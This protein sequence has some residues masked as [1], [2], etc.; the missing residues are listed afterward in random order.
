METPYG[1]PRASRGSSQLRIQGATDSPSLKG[2]LSD[3]DVETIF[4]NSASFQQK[5]KKRSWNACAFKTWVFIAFVIAILLPS[6]TYALDAIEYTV[7]VTATTTV[8]P[9]QIILNWTTDEYARSFTIRRKLK[10]DAVWSSPLAVLAGSAITFTDL[11]V[12]IGSAYEYEIQEETTIYPYPA[13]NPSDWVTAYGYIYAGIATPIND[14]P[15][16]VLLLVDSTYASDLNTELQQ[17]SN[18]LIGDG[19]VVARRDISRSSRPSEVKSAVLNEYNADPANLKALFLIGH[20]PVPYS[21]V[22][23]PDM[24][25]GHIGAW[26][27]DLYYGD[28]HGTWTDN[29]ANKTDSEDPRNDNVP[30]DGKFDQ[31]NI[32]SQVELQVGRVDMFDL[33]AFSPRTERDLLRQYLIKDH[34]FRQKLVTTERRGLVRD[35]FGDLAGDAP[36]VDAWRHFIPFFGFDNIRVAN[37]GE[38]FPILSDDSYLWSYGCGGGSTDKADGVGSTADFAATDVKSV[39]LMLHGS[40]FG[41]WDVTDNFL[42]AAIATPTYSLAAIWTGLPHWFMHHMG[43]GET[44]GYSTL[45]S[46]NNNNQLYKNRYNF[47]AGQVHVALLGDP[48]LRMDVV[49]PPGN[50]TARVSASL[51]LNWDSPPDS[52]YG[53]NVYHATSP[54]G[55][56]SKL[57]SGYV[58]GNSFTQRSIS[59]GQH[60]FMIR[61]V[62]LQTSPSGSY[63][64]LSQG[65]FLTIN[66]GDPNLPSVS[67][68]ASD[69]EASETGDTGQFTLSR[70]GDLSS[71]L[72]I[73]FSTGG[74]AQNGR[75]YEDLGTSVT[76][77]AGAS[78]V[79]LIVQP[80]ADAL[81]ENDE[82]VDLILGMGA[83]Y[84]IG[85][86]SSAQVVIHDLPHNSPPT[87][88]PIPDQTI[89]EDALL[90]VNFTIDDIDSGPANLTISATAENPTLI[91]PA[92]LRTTGT[93]ANRILT[94]LPATNQV[95]A[96][97]ITIT[98]SDGQATATRTFQLKVNPVNDPPTANPQ[99][100]STFANQPVSISLSGS[101]PENQALAFV[102]G[103]APTN[104]ILSGSL[105]N[106]IYQPKTNFFGQDSFTFFVNDG[107]SGSSAATVDIVVQPAARLYQPV[108]SDDG[109]VTLR[110]TTFAGR[111]YRILAT[112][113][114]G[115]S[116]QLLYHNT[117]ITNGIAQFTDSSTAGIPQRIY[118]VEWP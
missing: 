4:S 105:P 14:S 85:A 71:T 10:T 87:I 27:A 43:L 41:D 111:P 91:P 36:A 117:A 73:A 26:P 82:T 89:T 74:S 58:L 78:S 86:A 83:G 28:V 39:F 37:E 3:S 18:D 52:V 102:L 97:Q 66:A 68:S 42:R 109:G 9:P 63:Y 113:S 2:L 64:N 101:D 93:D 88:A 11:N 60:T 48:T 100:L 92:N 47:S 33:P 98:V 107:L 7:Q 79:T 51:Q 17:L 30:G 12:S 55:P 22:I 6:S 80:M 19:W 13:G 76:I 115:G 95:G 38:F 84:N 67:V 77:P 96:T 24:H 70:T 54:S 99:A 35:N 62:K 59:P 94:I 103:R 32:P 57:N 112:E 53:Y 45:V 75:D 1:I 5:R 40:Y 104:G 44:L 116:W 61:A 31:S 110:F 25:P 49:A 34:N 56:F 106:V 8:S 118:R 20:I 114:V 21:G 23:N 81:I 16:K 50:I 69:N 15:G 29:S 46:Q 65:A 108:R 90:T 72:T